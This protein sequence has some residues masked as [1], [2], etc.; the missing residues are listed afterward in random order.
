M[1]T[2]ACTD[3]NARLLCPTAFLS[4][5]L[6]ATAPAQNAAHPPL[7]DMAAARQ[8]LA[9]KKYT[10]ARD[11]YRNYL[12]AHP[13]SIDAE[14]GVADAELGLHEYEAAELDYRRVVAAQPQMW[15]AH[16]NLVIVEAELGRWGEFERERAVLRA[17]RERGA[18]GISARESDVIDSFE[19]NGHRWIAREYFEP[20]GRSQARYNFER[21][22]PEGRA[23][24]YVSLEPTAAAEDALKPSDEHVGVVPATSPSSASAEYSLNWYTGKAHGTVAQYPKGEPA[25]E[26]VRANLIHWLRSR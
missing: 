20:I 17:A 26:R 19:V 7:P 4:L 16:K 13:A 25:Y 22:S 14:L 3:R 24:E 10:Q 15:I 12:H 23:E 11:L 1:T 9:A 8:A 5:L 18:P 21:F 2:P 6:C